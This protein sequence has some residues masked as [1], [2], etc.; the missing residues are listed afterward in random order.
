MREY[1]IVFVPLQKNNPYTKKMIKNLHKAAIIAGER[2]VSYDEMFG[3]INLFARHTPKERGSKTVIL[4]ENREGWIY[5]FFSIW[6][7]R[8]IA[9]PVDASSTVHDW[10]SPGGKNKTKIYIVIKRNSL[11]DRKS[12][13]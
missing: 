5:A 3:R 9:V 11:G 4:S 13:V 10:I 1:G 12:V 7:N 6:Q 8:G 2:E